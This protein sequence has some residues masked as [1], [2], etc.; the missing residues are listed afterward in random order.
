MRAAQSLRQQ[1]QVAVVEAERFQRM[2]GR[3][4]IVPVWAGLAVALAHQVQLRREVEPAGILHVTAIDHVDQGVDAPFGS[5]NSVIERT[6]SRYTL[7]TCS[8]ARR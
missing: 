8:R 6:V 1:M 2:H 3:E 7:V 5:A 4:H